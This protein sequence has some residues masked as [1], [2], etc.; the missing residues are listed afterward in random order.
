MPTHK[1]YPTFLRVITTDKIVV[2][3]NPLQLSSFQII[4]KAKI[5]VKGQDE[6][7]EADT[8]RFYFPSGTGLTYSVGLD[9]TQED[10]NYLCNAL[11]E[12]LYLTEPEFRAKSAALEKARMEEWN[13]IAQEETAPELPEKVEEKPEA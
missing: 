3:I 11:Q 6:P 4:E 12:Y 5:K 2:C 10:F 8:I 13:K 9:I 1:K 7:V